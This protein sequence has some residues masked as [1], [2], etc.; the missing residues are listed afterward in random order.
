VAG[1]PSND[2][3]AELVC[4]RLPAPR[5]VDVETHV[6]DCP[7][8][9][10][11]VG[12][13]AQSSLPQL[14]TEDDALLRPGDTIGRYQILGL[15][16]AGGMGVV[17]RAHDPELDRPIAIKLLH[18]ELASDPAAARAQLLAEAQLMAKLRHPN[19]VAVHDV[20]THRD[21]VFMAM[22]L[23]PGETLRTWLSVPRPPR[24]VM[25]VLVAAG[26][27]LAAAHA[28]GIVHRDFKPE[29]VL[30]G[31]NH[32]CVA[33][34][35]LARPAGAGG[36]IAGT[37]RYM[38]P[39]QRA[40]HAPDP[41]ADQY[42]YCAVL[43]EAL[44]AT[45]TKRGERLARRF[46]RRGLQTDP[47][48]R[49][50][51]MDALLATIARRRTVVRRGWLAATA[52]VLVA[53]STTGGFAARHSAIDPCA[54]DTRPAVA[55]AATIRAA[56]DADTA[57][58]VNDRLAAWRT[59]IGAMRQ[60]ACR[61]ARVDGRESSELSDLRMEC[62]ADSVR[63]VTALGDV[64]AKPTA[65]L[66]DNPLVALDRAA[67]VTM[68]NSR[69]AVLEPLRPPDAPAARMRWEELRTRLAR[70]SASTAAGQPEAATMATS[71]AT[72]AA[73]SGFH[74][75]EAEAWQD[76]AE[77][78]FHHEEP[79]VAREALQHAI[80]AADAAGYDLLRA[81]LY[82][83][84]SA[85]ED[86]LD[87]RPDA[88]KLI[89]QG[90]ALAE[91]LGEPRLRW[92]TLFA[93]AQVACSAQDYAH[94]IELFRAE[95][96]DRGPIRDH[97]TA[98]V[99]ESLAG[100]LFLAGQRTEGIAAQQQS[101]AILT[102]LY[103][104]DSTANIDAIGELGDMLGQ[105][106][107][108]DDSV[109]ALER[110]IAIADRAHRPPMSEL[111]A[112]L[113]ETLLLVDRSRDALAVVERALAASEQ[114][115]GERSSRH[116]WVLLTRAKVFAKLARFDDAL[117]DGVAAIAIMRGADSVLFGLAGPLVALADV[118]LH[119]GKLDDARRSAVEAIAVF[120]RTPTDD[121]YTAETELG[122]VELA[123]RR[124]SE[125]LTHLER[126]IKLLGT[127]DHADPTELA[128]AQV[129]VARALLALGRDRSRALE[130]LRT[131]RT[132]YAATGH[133]AD[134]QAEIATLLDRA[135]AGQPSPPL[136][137]APPLV[138]SASHPLS[139]PN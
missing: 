84:Q 65:D 72:A 94:C 100:A 53:A 115:F 116:A 47:A 85:V 76:T 74:A 10:K 80:V 121:R 50:P 83:E 8:C 107:R 35:G 31:D 125:A 91:R 122:L 33:D 17:Y 111:E 75:I 124:P 134:E 87:R 70:A 45:R 104:K 38:A 54:T 39:E 138:G 6:A 93:E 117:R 24:E 102:E 36:D 96:A 55:D 14:A 130:L 19:V 3:I 88:A 69:R 59:N 22:E 98:E 81:E 82:F 2:T 21:L 60:A 57:Q 131:A 79:L 127:V 42:S 114:M 29:N 103:G 11:I 41:L 128:S 64:L 7:T 12:V 13:L 120:E 89:A 71:V 105:I 26:R 112:K 67:D 49:Y 27:G 34:F 108:L 92:A 101:L 62:I 15:I 118:Q 9:R 32:V 78:H 95:L 37:P 132:A 126:A 99:N 77:A 139:T 109:A 23:I 73:A 106:G 30:L 97:V 18:S 20:G 44:C 51:S 133:Y 46:A 1:C 123:S 86:T 25:R 110:A 119:A 136:S 66:A 43:D 40:G 56:F 129:G 5:A 68:C 113:A 16:G 28:H 137:A 63:R 4:H 52:L 48:A 61:A 58:R 90:K 135:G